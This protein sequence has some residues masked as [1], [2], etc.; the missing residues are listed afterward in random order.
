MGVF[1]AHRLGLSPDLCASCC[2]FSLLPS[3]DCSIMLCTVSSPSLSQLRP[4]PSSDVWFL[5]LAALLHVAPFT[6]PC[7]GG[8]GLASILCQCKHCCTGQNR[9]ELLCILISAGAARKIITK[10]WVAVAAKVLTMGMHNST[11]CYYVS[12]HILLSE[13]CP[14]TDVNTL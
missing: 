11:L 3:K 6:P 13:K 1:P 14:V 10:V 8:Q 5:W 7:W 4:S 9:L 12:H 2:C